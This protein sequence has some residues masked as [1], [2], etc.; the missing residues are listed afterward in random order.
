MFSS[1]AQPEEVRAVLQERR[2]PSSE[3]ERTIDFVLRTLHP[4]ACYRA[5][6]MPDGQFSLIAIAEK[7]AEPENRKGDV[8]HAG[9]WVRA[10]DDL[11]IAPYVLHLVCQNGLS[12]PP[13][14]APG[15]SCPESGQRLSNVLTRQLEKAGHLLEQFV[16]TAARPAPNYRDRLNALF[17]RLGVGGWSLKSAI[18]YVE[19]HDEPATEYDVINAISGLADLDPKI[20]EF[21]GQL[22]LNFATDEEAE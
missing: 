21:A 15:Y 7:R 16:L 20:A 18:E 1:I 19:R 9:V 14:L 12:L 2:P 4:A 3:L 11:A 22:A 8:S 10:D 5:E 13:E 6:W 17:F